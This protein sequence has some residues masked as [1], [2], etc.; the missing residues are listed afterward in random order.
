MI[1]LL[2][3]PLCKSANIDKGTCYV[4]STDPTQKFQQP[5]ARCR[6]CGCRA[7]QAAWQSRAVPQAPTKCPPNCDCTADC[8]RLGK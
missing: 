3:C 5:A 8:E 7:T 2:P 6:D 4:E 1:D